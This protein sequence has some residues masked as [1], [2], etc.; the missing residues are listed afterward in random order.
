VALCGGAS[1][2]RLCSAPT[3]RK[4]DAD[5]RVLGE[6]GRHQLLGERAKDHRDSADG[7]L[8]R[9][10][11][12]DENMKGNIDVRIEYPKGES[13]AAERLALAIAAL[14]QAPGF[15]FLDGSRIETR[16]R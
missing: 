16:R 13:D 14:A 11:T 2:G 15:E 7:S 3:Q 4:R 12:G 10:G 9:V 1:S 8:Y 5:V 6:Q